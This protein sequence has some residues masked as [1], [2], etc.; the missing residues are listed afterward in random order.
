LLRQ[1]LGFG[2]LAACL[3]AV[4]AWLN[5]QPQDEPAKKSEPSL[6]DTVGT[7]KPEK[8]APAEPMISI[9][10]YG[11]KVLKVEDDGKAFLL[12]VY[13]QT[14]TPTYTPGNPNSC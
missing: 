1:S 7:K 11:G 10:A 13:G 6:K 5:A 4:P 8:A 3:F 9:G 12:R 2:V 14:A